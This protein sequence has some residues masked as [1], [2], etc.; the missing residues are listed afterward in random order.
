VDRKTLLIST[1]N[2]DRRA[3]QGVCYEF[4][5]VIS[6]IEDAAIVAPVSARGLSALRSGLSATLRMGRE[7]IRGGARQIA[8]AQR[9]VLFRPTALDEDYDVTFFMCQFPR[10]LPNVELVTDW[11]R[12]SRLAVAFILESWTSTIDEF[13]AEISILDKFDHVF[14]LNAAAIPH[15]RRHTRTPVSFLPTAADCLSDL[16]DGEQPERVIDVLSIGRRVQAAHQR[17]VETVR[18]RGWFYLFDV[19]SNLKS[20]DWAAVR[21]ANAGMI[22][23]SRY[24]VVWDVSQS[25]K[26]GEFAMVDRALSTRYFEGAAGGAI[27]LG[28]RTA[29]AEFEACFDWPDAVVDV[30]PDG[31][32]LDARLDELEADPER[33]AAISRDNMLNCLRRHDWA[34]RW[35]TVIEALGLAVTPAHTAR[36]ARLERRA[37]TLANGA[38]MRLEPD[39]SPKAEPAALPNEVLDIVATARAPA[40]RAAQP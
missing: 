27:L 14:V 29:S 8:A 15:L 31:S 19:W 33:R 23:R 12:R 11:R 6:Q 21:A 2:C 28:S 3:S 34:H 32:D 5:N 10:D 4:L 37:S 1:F 30:A 36:F 18:E 9:G 20:A 38:A 16:T 22:R 26:K 35:S 25:I 39:A 13:S 24:F 40:R 17:L 7:S